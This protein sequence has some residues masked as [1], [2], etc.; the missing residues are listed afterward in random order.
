MATWKKVIV[1]G[2]DADLNQL[3]TSSH[4]TA[5]GNISASKWWYGDLPETEQ[6]VL[7]TYDPATGQMFSR[8]QNTFPGL[9]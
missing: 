3:F 6:N 5:S 1:S 4:I 2:S 8:A 7:V 9:S